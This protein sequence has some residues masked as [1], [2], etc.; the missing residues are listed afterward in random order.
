MATLVRGG[1]KPVSEQRAKLAALSTQAAVRHTDGGR[2]DYMA[3]K[4]RRAHEVVRYNTIIYP[5]TTAHR[6]RSIMSIAIDSKLYCTVRQYG[7]ATPNQ[8]NEGR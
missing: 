8:D 4:Q 5:V 6:H 7:L 1:S 2:R 3:V